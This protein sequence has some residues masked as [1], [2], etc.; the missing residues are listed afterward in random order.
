MWYFE[1]RSYFILYCC[2]SLRCINEY[3]ALYSCGYVDEL[4]L[5]CKSSIW[6]DAFQRSWYDIWLNTSVT[7]I[8]S[9]H[10]DQSWGLDTSVY[11]NLYIRYDR[12]QRFARLLNGSDRQDSGKFPFWL[13]SA[14][15][16]GSD[17][18]RETSIPHLWDITVW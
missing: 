1:Q 13:W 3:L 16:P 11:N 5:R 14:K 2:S 12:I 9:K 8:K 7:E 18:L 15:R 10:F 6:L 17:G 4:V